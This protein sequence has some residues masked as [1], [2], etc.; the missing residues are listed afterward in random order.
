LLAEIARENSRATVCAFTGKAASVLSRKIDMPVQTIHSAI[1]RFVGSYTD[2]HG[3]EELAFK[4]HVTDGRWEGRVV[5]VDEDSQIPEDLARDL[6]ATGARVVTCG[7]PGQLPPVRGRQFFSDADFELKQIHRQAWDSPIIR[8]AYNARNCMPY[9][10]DGEAFQVRKF[11]DAE[12]ILAADII[13]CWRN[14]TRIELNRIKRGHLGLSGLPQ[15]GEPVMCLKNDHDVGV[16]NGAVYMLLEFGYDQG[17]MLIGLMNERDEYVRIRRA[18]FEGVN[19]NNKG[20]DESTGFAFAYAATVHKAQ[21]DE[22]PMVILVDEYDRERDREKWLYTGIT[23]AAKQII[24][25]R[26]W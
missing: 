9:E 2:E 22:W 24:M 6:L 14:A 13:L 7:D 20:L 16:L 3:K 1:M 17:E 25:Q 19:E 26:N 4:R 8:Q 10:S 5:L 18:W 12:S 11:I 21:S 15:T 23:R